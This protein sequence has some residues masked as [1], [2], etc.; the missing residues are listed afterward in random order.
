MPTQPALESEFHAA[1]IQIYKDAKEEGYTASAFLNTV[2]EHGGL[3]A[4][5]RWIHDPAPTEGFLRL[6]EMDRLDL[7]VEHLVAFNTKYRELFTLAE[8]LAAKT[9]YEEYK[10]KTA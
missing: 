1:M 2:Y 7:S 6:W 4:A 9:R 3:A 10:R 8:R 5:K